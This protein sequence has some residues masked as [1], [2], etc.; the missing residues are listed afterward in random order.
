MITL[1]PKVRIWSRTFDLAPAPIAAMLVM[2]ATPMTIPSMVRQLRTGEAA[3]E[4]TA[5]H[6]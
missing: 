2:A 5:I 1:A 4:Q 3:S 6:V